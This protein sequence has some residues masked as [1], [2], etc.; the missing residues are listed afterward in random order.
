MISTDRPNLESICEFI[1]NNYRDL[2]QNG[3]DQFE[4]HGFGASIE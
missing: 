3:L 2:E 1:D 4:D